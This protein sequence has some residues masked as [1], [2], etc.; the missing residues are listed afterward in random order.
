MSQNPQAAMPMF[1]VQDETKLTDL[2]SKLQAKED[3]ERE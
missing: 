2:I 1:S 3:F